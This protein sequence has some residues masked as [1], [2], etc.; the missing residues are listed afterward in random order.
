MRDLDVT[1]PAAAFARQARME[2]RVEAALEWALRGFLEDVH[3]YALTDRTFMA[4]GQVS[5]MWE[6]RM[7]RAALAERLPDEVAEYVAEQQALSETPG[8]AY[9]TALTVMTT[10]ARL[11]WSAGF[12]A[13]VLAEALSFTGPAP[14]LTAAAPRGSK[15]AAQIREAFD[16]AL[17]GDPRTWGDVAKRDA[18]TAVTG[19]DGKMALAAMRRQGLGYK[20]W[21]TRRDE[22][23]RHTH[24]EANGQR[25]AADQPFNVGGAPLMHPGDRQGPMGETINCRCV[26]IGHANPAYGT[27]QLL[28]IAPE[29]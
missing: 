17:G 1:S 24:A 23:V 18:R 10:G 15:R 2:A 9:D 25:V 12:T 19:L 6:Q 11:E 13:D 16:T 22:K 5:A 7:G 3:G 4:R 21:V 29:V 14:S 27:T 28:F 26:I 20:Q 8:D